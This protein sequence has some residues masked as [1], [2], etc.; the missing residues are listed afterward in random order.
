ML[1]RIFLVAAALAGCATS[2]TPV[3]IDWRYVDNPEAR[4]IEVHF[5]NENDKAVCLSASYWPDP[6]GMLDTVVEGGFILV[7]KERF[8]LKNYNTAYC[9]KGCQLRIGGGEE[10]KEFLPYKYYDLP[11]RLW[12]E[13][14]ILE[15]RP[16]A[17]VCQSK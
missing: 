10:I 11:E 5:R 17:Y 12:Q 6:D 13:P 14:K 2:R 15:F 16:Q 1:L 9:P 4:R 7:G 3:P 8:A